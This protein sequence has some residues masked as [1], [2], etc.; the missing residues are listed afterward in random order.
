MPITEILARNAALYGEQNSLVE[1]NPGVREVRA[2]WKDYELV[3][4]NPE[5]KYRR[6]MTWREFDDK[7]NRLANFL[8]ERG[9]EKGH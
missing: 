3:E 8:L 5:M 1:I 7:A 9:L 4:T 6:E 2:N